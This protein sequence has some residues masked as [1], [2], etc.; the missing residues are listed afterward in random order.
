M[1]SS[2]LLAFSVLALSV[3][4]A[5]PTPSNPTLSKP[6]GEGTAL[7][8]SANHPPAAQLSSVGA[9]A[10]PIG[11]QIDIV[12][13][14]DPSASPESNPHSD[15]P[16][17]DPTSQAATLASLIPFEGPKVLDG[18]IVLVSIFSRL[19]IQSHDADGAQQLKPEANKDAV[20][21][22]VRDHILQP[23][24]S[25]QS[26][27]DESPSPPPAPSTP[28]GSTPGLA[29]SQSVVTYANWDIINAFAGTFTPA[30][31]NKIRSIDGVES[32]HEDGVMS[33]GAVV[34]QCVVSLLFLPP[35]THIELLG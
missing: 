8:H 27:N 16:G 9:D 20:I 26:M 3:V 31:I 33:A 21:Q 23:Q 24:V 28:A 11:S 22:S 4:W 14:A 2:S 5:T 25:Q 32:V 7:A 35:L 6:P 10:P 19:C 18:Y 15:P 17:L 29:Q 12:L 34:K 30:E 1:H 13:D